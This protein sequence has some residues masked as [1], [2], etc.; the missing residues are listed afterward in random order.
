MRNRWE[1]I[2]LVIQII[3]GGLISAGLGLAFIFSNLDEECFLVEIM[4]IILIPSEIFINMWWYTWHLPPHGDAGFVMILLVPP[5]QLF[6]MG[7]FLSWLI[8]YLLKRKAK[9][10]SRDGKTHHS[11]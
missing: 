8:I 9:R 3:S 6:L 11:K 10:A 4:R 5:V 2:L 7:C 1:K